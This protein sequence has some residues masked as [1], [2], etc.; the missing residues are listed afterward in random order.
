MWNSFVIAALTCL[1]STA[2]DFLAAY[3]MTHGA[4]AFRK[5]IMALLCR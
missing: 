4:F 3:A 2:L 1:I 5:A